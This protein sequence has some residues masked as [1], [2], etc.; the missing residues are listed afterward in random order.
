M[1]GL[2]ISSASRIGCVRE[3]NEDMI[4]VDNHFVRD[5]DYNT[6][7]TLNHEDRY[8]IAVA[9]GM[10]GHNRGDVASSDTLHN[11]QY[12][13]HDI[14]SGLNASEF[15]EA[16]VGWLE[17]IN[18]FVASKGRAD[19][20]YKGMGTT[21]VGVAYYAGDFYS[22]NCGDSRLYRFRDG[23]L[24]QLTTDHSLNNMLGSSKHSSIITNCI[25]GG[26][27]SSYI[28]VVKMTDDIRPGDIYLLCSDGLTDM[29]RDARISILL[30]EGANA[31]LLCEAA[32]ERGGL[33]N[34][35]ACVIT[36][37]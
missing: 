25:G 13:Y 33:D 21:L 27:T 9:D 10:G 26:C 4:L 22:L 7:L 1:I 28:D 23:E 6:L 3:Q 30:S 20:Q 31:N 18:N 5:D 2:E 11:L 34:V 37:K 8:I 35:S 17:S 15:N 12:Y 29:V 36:I 32:I 19:E 24:T 14:P 16:I